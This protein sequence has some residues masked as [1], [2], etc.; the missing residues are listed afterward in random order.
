M[1]DSATSST[2]GSF[3][4]GRSGLLGN[5][6]GFPGTFRKEIQI[7]RIPGTATSLFF[8]LEPKRK[9]AQ[10]P[11]RPPLSEPASLCSA[12]AQHD[13]GSH[14][15]GSIRA[16]YH[17]GRLPVCGCA[18]QAHP[19]RLMAST[20]AQR[21]QAELDQNQGESAVESGCCR[22]QSFANSPRPEP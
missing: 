20:S 2:D 11:R 3:G 22:C 18:C 7:D 15:A 13:V 5:R 1:M 21:R 14:A 16:R 4:F 10:Q 19:G 8:E 6:R 17:E 9:I 12:E